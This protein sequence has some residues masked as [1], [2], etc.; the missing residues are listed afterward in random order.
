MNIKTNFTI[1]LTNKRVTL[2]AR[3]SEEKSEWVAGIGNRCFPVGYVIFLDYDK[4]PLNYIIDEI[5]FIQ[6]KYVLSEFYVFSTKKG[7]H[8]VCLDKVPVGEL[9]DIM[10]S[11]VCDKDFR[12]VPLLSV[13]KTWVLRQTKKEGKDG[14][15][16][17]LFRITPE[18]RTIFTRERSLAHAKFLTSRYGIKI[19]LDETFDK[20][21]TI[22]TAQYY[23][24]PER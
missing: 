4:V 12:N 3:L 14:D 17:Y 5:T 10:D 7:Y 9:L 24:R 6:E 2:F 15:I 8:A 18:E 19:P 20:N 13:S 23:I 11:T 22:I 21:E 1:P 16:G